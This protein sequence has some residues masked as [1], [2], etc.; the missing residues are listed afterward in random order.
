MLILYPPVS[1]AAIFVNPFQGFFA[2]DSGLEWCGVRFS[3]TTPVS[4]FG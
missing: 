1:P 2:L 3:V 4:V